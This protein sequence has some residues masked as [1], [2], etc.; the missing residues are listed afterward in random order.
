M[1]DSPTTATPKLLT[2]SDVAAVLNS[3]PGT[4]YY[5]HR[6]GELRGHRVG[7][8]LRWFPRDVDAYLERLSQEDEA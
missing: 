3:E 7:K 6:V 8:Q 5:L 4:V 2:K 1:I